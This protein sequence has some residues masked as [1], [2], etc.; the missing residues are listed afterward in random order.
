MLMP[1]RIAARLCAG[2]AR[3]G[4]RPHIR[5]KNEDSRAGK[6]P[7]AALQRLQRAA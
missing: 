3:H 4:I 2:D 1:G 6:R 7:P 5:D